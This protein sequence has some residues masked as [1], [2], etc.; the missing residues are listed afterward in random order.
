MLLTE[1]G[2]SKARLSGTDRQIADG[3]GLP[4]VIRTKGAKMWRYE[5]RLSDE[6]TGW[7]LEIIRRS[8]WPRP[9]HCTRLPASWSKGK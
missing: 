2:H 7:H 8:V 6:K 3:G 9:E 1:P 4:L 5:F